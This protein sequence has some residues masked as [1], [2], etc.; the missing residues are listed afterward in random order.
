MSK[1]KRQV[2][3]YRDKEFIKTYPSIEETSSKT[4]DSIPTIREVMNG[5][6]KRGYSKRGYVYKDHQLT[7]EEIK[8]LPTFIEPKPQQ[9]KQ[10]KKD[11]EEEDVGFYLGKTRK[12]KVDKLKTYLHKALEDRWRNQSKMQTEFERRF[13]RQ[14][15]EDLT[16]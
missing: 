10:E 9:T 2:W 6:L 1:P 14:L 8:Q 13:L 4:H 12:E 3:V 15:L 5:K 11:E 16:Y 7:E